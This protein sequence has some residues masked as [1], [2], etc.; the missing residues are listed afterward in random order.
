MTMWLDAALA[1]LHYTAIFMLFGFLVAEAMAFRAV[2]G[3]G[4]LKE[5]PPGSP[6]Q[7]AG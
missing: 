4:G 3:A 2:Y 5:A 7:P 1:F 6:S